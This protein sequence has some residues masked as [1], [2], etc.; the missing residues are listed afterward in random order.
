RLFT[1]FSRLSESLYTD[2]IVFLSSIVSKSFQRKAA[3]DEGA[4]ILNDVSALEDDAEMGA[5]AAKVNIPVILMH[6]RGIP[7]VMQEDTS[8][9][10][11]FSEVQDYLYKRIDYALSCGINE[12]NIILDPGIGFG[13]NLKANSILINKCGELCNGEYPVLM[14]LSRKTCIGEMTGRNVADRLYGSLAA[15]LIS[16]IKGACMI[17]VHDVASSLDTLKVLKNLWNI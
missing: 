14:A 7:S 2:S 13:K 16:V 9:R 5:F 12:A 3:F 17:R 1:I 10:N 6:K 15:N 4:D 8:Y 11:V